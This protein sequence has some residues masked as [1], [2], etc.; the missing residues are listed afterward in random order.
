MREELLQEVRRTVK[1]LRKKAGKVGT[2]ESPSSEMFMTLGMIAGFVFILYGVFDGN[3]VPANISWQFVTGAFV[4]LVVIAASSSVYFLKSKSP[5]IVGE[6]FHN[7]LAETDPV[8]SASMLM[9][10]DTIVN[11]FFRV[12]GFKAMKI[13]SEGGGRSGIA[14][15]PRIFWH[16]SGLKVD[17]AASQ[18]EWPYEAF[19]SSIRKALDNLKGFNRN[20][21]P[22]YWFIIPANSYRYKIEINSKDKAKRGIQ[23]LLTIAESNGKLSTHYS[24]RL[25]AVFQVFKDTSFNL[26]KG[27][28]KAPKTEEDM[29]HYE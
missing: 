5:V 6:N 1:L 7:S 26:G 11:D 28:V 3:P 12:G 15:V 29:T 13:Y 17:V 18:I 2:G 21:D 8:G 25:D 23:E 16:K 27:K 22:L 24:D 10:G 4:I 19:P 14:V 20:T 9:Q